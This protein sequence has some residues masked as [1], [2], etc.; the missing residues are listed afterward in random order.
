[1]LASLTLLDKILKD[2]ATSPTSAP[3]MFAAKANSDKTSAVVPIC[4]AVFAKSSPALA[5]EKA[6]F[7]NAAAAAAIPR[8][9][10]L[11]IFPKSP[12][13]LVRPLTPFDAWSLRVTKRFTLL[14]AKCLYLFFN[15]LLSITLMR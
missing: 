11:S 5:A 9:T 7:V 4:V 15:C 10:G 6:N 2:V 1:M 14:S 8:V 13:L 12:N 3:P